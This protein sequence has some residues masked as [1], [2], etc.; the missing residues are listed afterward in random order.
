LSAPPGL[1]SN[2]GHG[3]NIENIKIITPIETCADLGRAKSQ[4]VSAGNAQGVD[5][6]S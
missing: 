3:F 4:V 6:Y 1:P 5:S 2:T